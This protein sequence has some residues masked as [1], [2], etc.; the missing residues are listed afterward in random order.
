[1]RPANTATPSVA[2]AYA[3]V[4]PAVDDERINRE[5]LRALLQDMK[6]DIQ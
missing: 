3:P 5:Y 4:R 1:M 2:P 6:L